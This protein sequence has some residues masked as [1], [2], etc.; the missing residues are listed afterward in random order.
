MRQLESYPIIL[1][2]EGI[3]FN[4]L[5]AEKLAAIKEE[6][7]G[8]DR[9]QPET[10]LAVPKLDRDRLIMVSIVQVNAKIIRAFPLFNAYTDTSQHRTPQT[11]PK[12]FGT[13]K[14][15]G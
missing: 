13:W 7:W 4:Y 12:P 8:P 6:V 2:V 14:D 9:C 11:P 1:L 15:A 10:P 5:V 3:W